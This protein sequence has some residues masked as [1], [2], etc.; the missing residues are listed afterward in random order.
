MNLRGVDGVA[1]EAH[2]DARLY[3]T[4]SPFIC[5]LCED[6]IQLAG[7]LWNCSMGERTILHATS[8]DVCQRCLVC[9]W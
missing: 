8:Y 9:C 4:S 5:D 1:S 6:Y 3:D 7:A 2:L